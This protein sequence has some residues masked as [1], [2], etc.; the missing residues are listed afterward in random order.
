MNELKSLPVRI[1]KPLCVYSLSPAFHELSEVLGVT[2]SLKHW[3]PFL[4]I[5]SYRPPS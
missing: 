5:L 4:A 1:Q 2:Q 3:T